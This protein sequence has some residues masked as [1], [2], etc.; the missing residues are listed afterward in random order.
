MHVSKEDLLFSDRPAGLQNV[1]VY[2]FFERC[3]VLNIFPLYTDTL[4]VQP[5]H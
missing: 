5:G 1:L 3:L 4:L 2:L